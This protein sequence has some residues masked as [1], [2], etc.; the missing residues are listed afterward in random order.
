M[1]NRTYLVHLERV[2]TGSKLSINVSA[3]SEDAARKKAKDE[4]G[5]LWKIV[6]VKVP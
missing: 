2:A 3:M 4:M 1:H 5:N 6:E